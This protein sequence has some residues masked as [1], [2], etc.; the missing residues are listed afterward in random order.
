MPD[1]ID[2]VGIEI[3]NPIQWRCPGMERERLVA[4]FGRR[5]IFHGSIDN[6]QTLPFGT[7]DD[8]VGEVRESVRHLSRRPLDLRPLPQSSAGQPDR[9]HRGHVRGHPRVGRR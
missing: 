7:V 6:Q 4:D 3:L 9:E 5:I 8:V 1:L 2:R